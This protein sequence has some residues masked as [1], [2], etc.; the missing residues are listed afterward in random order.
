MSEAIN[1]SFI[2]GR[3]ARRCSDQ[4][5]YEGP[6]ALQN[7]MAETE[8]AMRTSL[9]PGLMRNAA[10]NIEPASRTRC[11]LF[12]ARARVSARGAAD[13]KAQNARDQKLPIEGRAHDDACCYGPASPFGWGMP[14]RVTSTSIDMQARRRG[15]LRDR[16]ASVGT[17]TRRSADL[18]SYRHPNAL[19]VG[20]WWQE[21][22]GFDRPSCTRRPSRRS[23][24]KARSSWPSSTWASLQ[25]RAGHRALQA[26]RRVF[27]A[28]GA[29]SPSSPRDMRPGRRTAVVRAHASAAQ[30]AR[31][32]SRSSCSTSTGASPS[33]KDH[34]EPGVCALL[35]PRS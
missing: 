3:Q 35:L 19:G 31:R 25:R 27:R 26:A 13:E 18:P 6:I 22:R 21:A 33:P 15:G 17:T 1:Y 32:S 14:D 8:S 20:S 30:K 24:W 16:P 28:C 5:T 34:L 4:P 23:R 7:P 2:D 12:G 10:R 11:A 9:M 29:T